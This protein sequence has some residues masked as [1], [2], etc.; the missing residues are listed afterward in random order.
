MALASSEDEG[1]HDDSHDH[2]ESHST[3]SATA[4]AAAA[5]GSSAMNGT[6]TSSS[7]SSSAYPTAV[8]SCHAHDETELYCLDGSDEWEV[9]SEWDQNN[10]PESFDDCHN[11]GDELCV[12][13]S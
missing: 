2:D 4:T 5:T 8:T 7:S 3:T 1:E 9:T 10:P 6:T 11:D 13:H 12:V